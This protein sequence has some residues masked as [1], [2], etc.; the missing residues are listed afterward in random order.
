MEAALASETAPVDWT[1]AFLDELRTALFLTG[2]SDLERF[3]DCAPVVTGQTAA[4]LAQL[5]AA[6]T[7]GV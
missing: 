1:A 3:H 4:W 7:D 2:S 6:P 5:A